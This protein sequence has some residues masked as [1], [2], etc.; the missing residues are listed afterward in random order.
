MT[1]LADESPATRR[2]VTV[3]LHAWSDGDAA[4]AD[5]LTEMVYAQ[6]RAMAGKHFVTGSFPVLR[7]TIGA[8]VRGIW[9]R[10]LRSI[11]S[12]GND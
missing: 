1:D 7:Q 12:G 8:A 2:D 5:R 6:V 9:S 4:A 11:A 3:L 10:A